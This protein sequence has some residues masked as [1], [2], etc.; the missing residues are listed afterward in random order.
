MKK[1]RISLRINDIG[2]LSLGGT[3]K[4]PVEESD[5]NDIQEVI[6]RFS[7]IDPAIEILDGHEE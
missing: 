1:M 7:E 3:V 2:I 5:A 4:I 6:I